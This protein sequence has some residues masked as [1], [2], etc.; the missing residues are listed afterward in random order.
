MIAKMLLYG[1]TL[2]ENVFKHYDKKSPTHTKVQLTL[3]SP[4]PRFK[5]HWDFGLFAS[6]LPF[7][8][9][10]F[11]KASPRQPIIAHLYTSEMIVYFKKKMIIALVS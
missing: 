4:L 3:M 6:S 8:A 7:L 11:F 9:E 1:Y 2:V 5:S 10:V